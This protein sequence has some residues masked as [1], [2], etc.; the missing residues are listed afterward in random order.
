MLISTVNTQN[1]S[2]YTGTGTD[3]R[4]DMDKLNGEYTKKS[5]ES[6]KILKIRMN[7]GFAG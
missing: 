5:A 1:M 3:T 7:Y 2:I 6:F 4:M